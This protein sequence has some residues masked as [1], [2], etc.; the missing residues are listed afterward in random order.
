MYVEHRQL[1]NLTFE[2]SFLGTV[3]SLI[4]IGVFFKKVLNIKEKRYLKLFLLG[5]F[6]LLFN[7]FID[8]LDA[9]YLD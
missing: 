4:I 3:L 6:F 8:P 5:L 7:I 9:W 2:V 1:I